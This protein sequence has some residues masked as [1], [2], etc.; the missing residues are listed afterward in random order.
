MLGKAIELFVILNPVDASGA[1]KEFY[2]VID[3]A[4]D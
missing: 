4:P 2:I 1:Y 3:P